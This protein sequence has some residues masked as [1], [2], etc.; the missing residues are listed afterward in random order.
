LGL[1][2]LALGA[3]NRFR[4]IHVNL[5]HDS[6]QSLNAYLHHPMTQRC[7]RNRNWGSIPW[8]LMTV[9]STKRQF[10]FHKKMVH[11]QKKKN[12]LGGEDDLDHSV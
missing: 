3:I 5:K 2:N 4:R 9:G 11:L 10:S 1:L 6:S 12:F 8:L 7:N